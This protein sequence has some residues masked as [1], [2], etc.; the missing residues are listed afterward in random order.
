MKINMNLEFNKIYVIQSLSKQNRD[1][2]TGESIYNIVKYF[3]PEVGSE[4]I[5]VENPIEFFN[6]LSRIENECKNSIIKP[7]IHLEMHGLN[8]RSGISLNDGHVKWEELYSSLSSINRTS[9]FSLYLTMSV[10]HGSYIMILL[11][12]WYPAPFKN[13]LG[14]FEELPQGNFEIV[15][16]AFFQELRNSLSIDEALVALHR[17]NPGI[18]KDY[19]FI[20]AEQVFKNVIQQYFNTK[21]TPQALKERAIRSINESELGTTN[22]ESRRKYQRIF[23]KM[24]LE[25]MK[26]YYQESKKNFFMY[27]SFPENEI[28][29]C[30]DWEPV[31]PK[32]ASKNRAGKY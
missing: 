14:S 17:A 16:D 23:E 7:L 10:C 21:F 28:K 13:I 25:K 31:F 20:T 11:H 9:A 2:L 5:K 8:D 22:R 29:Y 3:P 18:P 1:I 19:R 12:P 32:I 27:D 4:F 26:F 6:C 24:T 15:Y 30:S